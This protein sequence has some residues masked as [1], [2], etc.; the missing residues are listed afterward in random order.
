M[1]TGAMCRLSSHM[2]KE[3]KHQKNTKKPAQRTMAEKKAAKR[4]KKETKG[5][6]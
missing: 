4:A 6:A 5:R 3:Q 2:A 1:T